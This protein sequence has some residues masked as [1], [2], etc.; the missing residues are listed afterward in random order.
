MSAETGMKPGLRSQIDQ[1]L[2]REGIV[3][4]T[5]DEAVNALVNAYHGYRNSY[6]KVSAT[7]PQVKPLVRGRPPV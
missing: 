5:D 2:S 4:A 3:P 7:L 1:A 6:E